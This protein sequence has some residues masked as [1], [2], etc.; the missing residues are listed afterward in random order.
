VHGSERHTTRGL[1]LT[2]ASVEAIARRV[3]EL[4]RQ[5]VL[6][7]SASGPEQLL[8]PATLAQRLGQSRD[9]VYAHAAE[10]GAIRVGEGP[11]PRILFDATVA[12]E[13]LRQR[14][15]TSEPL[16][17]PARVGARRRASA[18]VEPKPAELLPIGPSPNRKSAS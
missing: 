15:S 4:L 9:W 13:R 3:A 5:D 1:D 2:D 7:E 11:K 10:L 6:G 18:R 17:A 16:P 8:T 14:C 12:E